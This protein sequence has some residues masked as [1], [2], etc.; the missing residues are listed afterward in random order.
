M[1]KAL[2]KKEF[3]ALVSVFTTGK[4]GKRRSV[5]VSLAFAALILYAIGAS[6]YV[7]WSLA[8]SLCLPLTQ[9]GMAWIYFAFMGVVSTGVS[10]ILGIFIAKGKLYEAKDNDL[11]LS[12]PIP[13]W[14]VLFSR[15][16]GIYV[17]AFCLEGLVFVPAIIRYFTLVGF[18]VVPFLCC[19]VALFILPF[20]S[21][22]ISC[23]LGWLIA[24]VSAKIPGKN[25]V[26]TVFAVAFLIVYFIAYSKVNEYLGYLLANGEAVGKAMK[27]ALYPFAQLGYACTGDGLGLL[28]Y[29][30]IFVG[31]F[32]LV[33]LL[34]SATY[35]RLATTNKGSR[36]VKY[37]GKG[38]RGSSQTWALVKKELKRYTKNSMVMLNCFLGPVLLVIIPFVLLFDGEDLLQISLGL[39]GQFA[40]LLAA[41]ICVAASTNLYAASCVSMEGESVDVVRVLPIKTG[42]ILLAKC[43]THI[44]TT[45][46]P[47][48]F[49]SVFL[50][51]LFK[52][53]I[54]DSVC[55]VIVSLSFVL[56]SAV[57]GVAT[58]LLFP[59][60]KWTNEVAVVKQ[61]AASLVS[62]FGEMG[63]VGL[64]VGG[65]FLFGKY[66]PQWGY[67]LV[68]GTVLILATAAVYL[69]MK[70]KGVKIFEA[71]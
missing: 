57:S 22:V 40:M 60:L 67:L 68:C 38:Y 62:M 12:M 34:M 64:L 16:A 10:V 28:L 8:D 26:E 23:L 27:T 15:I 66:L 25:I 47:A 43:L 46:L 11:L 48:L 69:W 50:C 33:Y 49:S 65:Y 54:T 39:Q 4:D 52:Q 31:V 41:F 14:I 1:L 61:S 56:F 18:S 20:L 32:A 37:T 59:N 29:T 51:V 21:L 17:L 63:V 13:S 9:G 3:Y 2:F 58:N 44:L 55:V 7:F 45:A 5:G 36:K 53:G 6:G 42:N 35:L 24:I 30:L 71:L 19:L 70:K